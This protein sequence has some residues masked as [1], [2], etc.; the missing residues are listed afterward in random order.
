MG[1]TFT[2]WPLELR[3]PCLGC[4]TLDHTCRACPRGQQR[5]F[6][7]LKLRVVGALMYGFDHF[8]KDG[9]TLAFAMRTGFIPSKEL[10]VTLNANAEPTQ[11]GGFTYIVSRMWTYILDFVLDVAVDDLEMTWQ[12]AVVQ[13]G[14]RPSDQVQCDA[15]YFDG[16]P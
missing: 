15:H 8:D 7:K 12:A 6:D 3:W 1:A 13:A 2:I 16:V 10:S 4:D 9:D 5:R 11:D 14:E